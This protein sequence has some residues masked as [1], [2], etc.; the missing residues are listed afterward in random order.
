MHK[1]R[2]GPAPAADSEASGSCSCKPGVKDLEDPELLAL[3][4]DMTRT[5]L[6][7]L[8]PEDAD[9]LWRAELQG[10]TIAQIARETGRTKAEAAERLHE[11]RRCLCRFVVLTLAPTECAC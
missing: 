6:G 11:A 9:I 7:F 5:L 3:I 4:E 8:E 1:H 2:H 10:Q